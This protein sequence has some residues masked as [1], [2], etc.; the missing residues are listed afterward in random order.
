MARVSGRTVEVVVT[1]LTPPPILER[2][3]S[4]RPIVLLPGDTFSVTTLRDL[5]EVA[6]E[7]LRRQAFKA[8]RVQ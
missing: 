6:R 2:D 5:E 3:M 8:E 4:G 1:P 7:A